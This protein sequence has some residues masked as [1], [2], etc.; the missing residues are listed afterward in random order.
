VENLKAGARQWQPVGPTAEPVAKGW[1][2]PRQLTTVECRTMVGT[3]AAAAR[4]AVD[5]GFDTIEIHAEH[6]YLLASF[7]SPVSNTR[8][9]EYGGDRAGRMR[10]P[11]EI[12][13]AVRREM[14]ASMP[15]FVRVSSVDGTMKGW[16]MDDTVA[17]AHELK[18]RGVDV[19]DCSWGG[20]AG[21]A[22]AAQMTRS[23]GFQVPF[24]ERVRNEADINTMAVGIILEAQQA[25]AKP[26]FGKG[27]PILSLSAASRSS[28]PI[29]PTTGR[30][31]SASMRASRTG[32][33]SMAGGSRNGS[34][35]ST[36]LP[37]RL[38]A[39]RATAEFRRRCCSGS[40][41]RL[42]YQPSR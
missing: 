7:L 26:S 37:R 30:T 28:I 19:V 11:L 23:L 1:L 9:D 8:N 16:N 39:L 24:A 17:F 18:V 5:A 2:M 21:A 36:V 3:W 41:E 6:G 27:R 15:L 32:H 10:L 42:S 29:S 35:R 22:T 34:E 40:A 14:P 33:P 12:V 4:R 31:T 20:I 25:E 38:A 13:K